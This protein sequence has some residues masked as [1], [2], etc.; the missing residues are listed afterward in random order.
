MSRPKHS[1]AGLLEGSAAI[2]TA[3]GAAIRGMP[4]GI[5]R[6]RGAL[7]RPGRTPPVVAALLVLFL[8]AGMTGSFT[9]GVQAQETEECDYVWCASATVKDGDGSANDVGYKPGT[10]YP[11]STLDATTFTYKEVT[12]TIG[13]IVNDLDDGRVTLLL[14]PLPDADTIRPLTFRVGDTVLPFAEG[15]RSE[16][17]GG[18]SWTDSTE[19][20][21]EASPFVDDASIEFRIA[22]NALPG[23]PVIYLAFGSNGDRI[24][25]VWTAP[26]HRGARSI[27]GYK[28][29][30]SGDDGNTWS[31]LAEN[32]P[33]RSFAHNGL[34]ADTTYDY[35]VSAFNSIGAGEPSATFSG[36]SGAGNPP[37]SPTGLSAVV[38]E[39]TITL[40]WVPPVRKG[41]APITGYRIDVSTEQET[42]TEVAP[43]ASGTTY[44]HT[45][46]TDGVRYTYRVAAIT[47]LGLGSW[48]DAVTAITTVLV[49][50]APTNVTVNPFG[51]FN[52]VNWHAPA[53]DGGATISGY[54]VEVST[55]EETWTEIVSSVNSDSYLHR[56]VTI[57]TTYYYRVSARNSIGLGAPS[58]TASVTARP[59]E[60]PDA[61]PNLV[62]AAYGITITLSW[63][64]PRFDGNDPTLTYLVE[65]STDEE[66]WET[67]EAST[68]AL[69]YVHTGLDLATTYHYRVTGRNSSLAR[70]AVLHCT[71]ATTWAALYAPWRPAERHGDCGRHND[72]PVLG[73]SRQRRGRGDF[74]ISASRHRPTGR[75]GRRLRRQRPAL[76]A[77]PHRAD[78]WKATYRY[79]VSARN[80][81]GLEH[82]FRHHS[83]DG[84]GGRWRGRARRGTS[85]PPV[86]DG[87]R[88][89]CRGTCRRAT[90]GLQSPATRLSARR[91]REF[92]DL[93][94]C[95]GRHRLQ[96]HLP[97]STGT[98]TPAP[99][100]TIASRRSMPPAPSELRPPVP[101]Q[102][103]TRRQ[104]PAR[105]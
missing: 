105:H 5:E 102:S 35:R 44:A 80:S 18:Y 54:R 46:R 2:L 63:N 40:S 29:E 16:A 74:R 9:P 11:G 81:E 60:G 78:S 66:T 70:R 6:R 23:S 94:C 38:E 72:Q 10:D 68:T 75:R 30:V 89:N 42:W 49:P 24:T 33:S 98:A 31:V 34:L 101:A 47:S 4:G 67:L 13:G 50:G 48:S 92:H 86:G 53:S 88:L 95:G 71:M 51:T 104:F 77:R 27:E 25:L 93:E 15:T 96:G 64:R 76:D 59:V 37:R 97:M 73:G 103:L 43:S 84:A 22:K 61:P 28:V 19:F 12:Y 90:E 21:E 7:L 91:A 1:A 58:D 45:G 20:G 39:S 62:A 57:G 56:G 52:D 17:D 69:S 26:S 82:A 8:A 14:S 99:G 32:E 79:R 65:E 83:G 41:G 55:D 3:V 85:P 36:S 100:T 87:I